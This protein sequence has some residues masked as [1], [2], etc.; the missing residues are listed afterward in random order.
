MAKRGALELSINTIVV[1]VIAITL[2]TLGLAFVKQQFGGLTDIT[3]DVFGTAKTEIGKIHGGAKFTAPT[4]VSI[5]QGETTT[6][7]VFVAN[8]GSLGNNPIT[9]TVALTPVTSVN[10]VSARIIS[11]PTATLNVG[12]EGTFTVAVAATKT[13]PLST[14]S[15]SDPAYSITI[16]TQGQT[17]TYASGGFVIDVQPTTG[18]F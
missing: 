11:S 7:A 10:G 14:G 16:T 15:A 12:Q 18:I 4:Q 13:A 2:L 17:G 5:K 1:V 6:I 9:V 8:D 3:K